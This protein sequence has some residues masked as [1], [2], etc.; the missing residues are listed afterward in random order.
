MIW[1]PHATVAAIVEK[2]GK[3]LM[4]EENV[5]G[6]IVYNQ[7]AGHLDPNENLTEAVIRETREETAWLFEPEALVG[8]YLWEQP[9][10]ER[11]FLRFAFCGQCTDH[12]KAQVLDDGILQAVWMSRDELLE[13]KNL[14]SPMVIRNIDDYIAGIRYPLDVLSTVDY[15]R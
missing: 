2:N 3:Y 6:E 10:T 5:G 7:P 1:K 15:S 14:R 11:T 4:V 9:N 8:I 12:R 13:C